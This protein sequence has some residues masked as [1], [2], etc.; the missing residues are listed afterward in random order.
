MLRET[1][2]VLNRI[3]SAVDLHLERGSGL[4]FESRLSGAAVDEMVRR[5]AA[6][7]DEWTTRQDVF[8]NL[9]YFDTAEFDRGFLRS[10]FGIPFS[11]EIWR[12][13][14]QQSNVPSF[15]R[16]GPAAGAYY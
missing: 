11:I 3:L 6:E 9:T 14:V 8:D 12:K 10:L 4:D 2:R 16:Q 15:D 13:S 7:Y 5:L 1:F